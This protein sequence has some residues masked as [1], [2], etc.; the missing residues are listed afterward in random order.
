MPATLSITNPGSVAPGDNLLVAW[1]GIDNPTPK[2][3][4]GVWPSGQVDL[5]PGPNRVNWL[6][7]GGM[8]AGSLSL[9]IPLVTLPG[10]YDVRLNANNQDDLLAQLTFSIV[11]PPMT[12]MPPPD[13]STPPPGSAP[14]GGSTPPP[15][16]P[17]PA[18]PSLPSVDLG[19]L[20]R[21][22]VVLG[23]GGLVL[24]WQFGLIGRRR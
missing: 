7:T 15:A 19:A 22:P 12:S 5:G 3:W 6:Y 23:V 4:I 8:S 14:P 10:R 18:A 2:D 24:A 1:A 20:V 21:N 13:T 9:P 16:K 17:A 11:A